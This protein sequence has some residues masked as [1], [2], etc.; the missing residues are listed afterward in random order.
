[1]FTLFHAP[2]SRSSRVVR[3]LIELGAVETTDI[4]IT[5]I[6]RNDG[7]VGPGE[8]S[9]HPEGK[10]PV[11]VHDGVTIWESN[12]ILLYLT[13]LFPKARMGLPPGDPQRGRFL[14][15][16]AWYGNVVEPVM[17]FGA[18]ELAHPVLDV[19]F[20][21]MPE[22]VARLSSALSQAPF[23]MGERFTTADLLLVSP[24]TWFPETTPD[25]AAIRSWIQ[26][27]EARPSARRAAEFDDA[28]GNRDG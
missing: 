11:L 27:C 6:T 24:F 25:D 3:L 7:T 14:S 15:W 12:A 18:A 17:V 16:L 13:D 2:H 19:T 21:G 5:S 23:L 22:I 28:Q 1:M 26:R 8:Q 20:R 4:R 10:V 9:P